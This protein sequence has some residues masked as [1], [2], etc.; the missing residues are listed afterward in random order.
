MELKDKLFYKSHNLFKEL[1]QVYTAMYGKKNEMTYGKIIYMKK[2]DVKD[3]FQHDI[4][5]FVKEEVNCGVDTLEVVARKLHDE[6][7]NPE[8]A[9]YYYFVTY[10]SSNKEAI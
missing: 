7:R 3:F 2:L 8:S 9:L 1:M 6:F 10:K 5:V 4:K